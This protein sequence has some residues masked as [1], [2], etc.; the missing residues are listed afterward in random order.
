M[1]AR[2]RHF[3]P[4]GAG[5]VVAFDARYTGFANNDAVDTWV[6]RTGANDATQ[7]NPANQ[8]LFK[9]GQLNGNPAI[10]FD[11]SNDR[12]TFAKFD[13]ST[14]W[15]VLLVK[16]TS[17]NTFQAPFCVKQAANN[18]AA[19][20][21]GL[22][23]SATYGPVIVGANGNSSFYGIGGTLRTNEWR[24][25]F[26]EWVGG[27]TNGATFYR[28]RDDGANIALS[29]SATIGGSTNATDSL[30]GATASGSSIVSHFGGQIASLAVGFDLPSEALRKR[31]EHAAAFSFKHSMN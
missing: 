17:A 2:H 20:E 9:T 12:L 29:N 5:A 31:I 22:N 11:A 24:C 27:G 21:I 6:S 1:R 10:E 8:P 16:R 4:K 30:I 3:N 26:A 23:N 15:A 19:F 18:R 28:C 13:P 25:L 7:A 14:A